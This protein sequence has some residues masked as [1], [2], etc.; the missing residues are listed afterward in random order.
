[1][2]RMLAYILMLALLAVLAWWLLRPDSTPATA[3][4]TGIDEQADQF[5]ENIHMRHMDE[6]GQLLLELRARHMAHFPGDGRTTLD[7]IVLDYYS[8]DHPPWLLEAREGMIPAGRR[9]VHLRGD[10]RVEMRMSEDEPQTLLLT[11]AL[12]VD[13]QTRHATSNSG[14]VMTRA[15]SEL[16]G[17]N[18]H[19]DLDTGIIRLDQNVRGRH[20]SPAHQHNAE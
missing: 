18:M 5:M 11:P 17:Q 13:L 9:Y 12:D 8:P 14:V 4:K 19:T 20:E 10:V 1:M 15:H 16:R 6:S 2:K 7:T 3:A